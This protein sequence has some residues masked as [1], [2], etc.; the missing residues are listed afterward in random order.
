M[1][2][3]QY[4]YGLVGK[5]RGWPVMALWPGV[6]R[7]MVIPY[8]MPSATGMLAR[9]LT[10]AH[11]N[12]DLP[13]MSQTSVIDGAREAIRLTL[14]SSP[15]MAASSNTLL[16]LE[17]THRTLAPA[18]DIGGIN[19]GPHGDAPARN[20]M[21]VDTLAGSRTIARATTFLMSASVRR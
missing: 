7:R 21:A 9:P 15:L 19:C 13:C 6:D 8:R 3:G 20:R 11:H 12:G 1:R 2:R 10:Q 16:Q 5:R 4:Q 18:V 14:C 17:F